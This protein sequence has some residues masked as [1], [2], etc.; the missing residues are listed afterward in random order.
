MSGTMR[1]HVHKGFPWVASRDGASWPN[2]LAKE[3]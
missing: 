1:I 3:V 2:Y